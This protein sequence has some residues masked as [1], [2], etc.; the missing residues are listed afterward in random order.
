M[1]TTAA[2]SVSSFDAAELKLKG[3][4]IHEMT[5][6]SYP[7]LVYGRRDCYKIVLA[8]SDMHICYGDQAFDI[9]GTFLFF[10][11]PRIPYSC[12]HRRAEQQG[13]ACL[14][15]EDFIAGRERTDNLLNSPIFRFDGRP[16]IP[17]SEEQA[18]F[19]SGLYQRML[20]VYNGD[21]DRKDEMLRSCID[22]I[23]HEALRVQPQ[24]G[25]KQKNAA[26]RITYLFMELLENQFPIEQAA[27]TLQLRSAQDFAGRLAVHVNYLNR[28]V[29]E[30]TGKPISQ[31]IAERIAAEAK[32]LLQHTNWSVA[33]IA[34]GLGFE[35][36]SYFNNYFRRV[37]GTTPSSFRKKE[38]K[39]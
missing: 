18:A 15:T 8:T 37:T 32:A 28:S 22:L 36:P 11:N 9:H 12:E 4:K 39:V 7:A 27:D 23:I 3:F 31:H 10:G 25:I 14:F 13:Y 20:M 17:L 24:N 6:S 16:V 34:Y 19:I 29:K 33:D 2:C 21:Y 1:K 38:E 26:A 30:V 5:G 35:Y